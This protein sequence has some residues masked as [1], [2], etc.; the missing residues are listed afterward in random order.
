MLKIFALAVALA[1]AATLAHA[2]DAENTVRIAFAK[3]A[4]TAKPEMITKS[5]MPG[6][7]AVL[8]QGQVFYITAD[9][10]YF[11]RGDIF[12]I[13][14]KTDVISH[15]LA[16]LRR[17]GLKDIPQS[18]R[19][20]FAPPNPK[21]TVIVFTDVDCPYCRNF[22]KQIAA[23]NQVG[24]AVEY[25]FFPLSI[26]PGADAKAVSVWCSQDRNAAYTAAMNGQD[27]GKKQCEN[28]VAE[29]L[30]LGLKIGIGAT[31]TMLTT[32][33]LQVNGNAAANP[34]ALLAE[35]DRLDKPAAP[36]ANAPK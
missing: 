28:P 35:L 12:N 25:V 32:D 30:A 22:H 27:P 1:G 5:E 13:E 9:G 33:G 26:H 18:K 36:V 6:F 34:Q 2:D 21:H 24:I 7:Y 16:G 10:K 14:T 17:A 20:V 11:F 29:T 3:L 23:F 15:D 4:P 8:H 31:P 19:I